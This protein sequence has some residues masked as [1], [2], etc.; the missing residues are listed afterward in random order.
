M[1]AETKDLSGSRIGIFGKGG[2][3]KSTVT[4]LL[5]RALRKRGY[6]VCVVDADSTNVGL[7]QA[8]GLDQS[9]E[10]LIDYFGGMVFSGGAV[11]CPVDDP[12]PLSG[13]KISVDEL[14]S[15]FVGRTEEGIWVVATGKMGERGP[16]AGCD[17]PMAKIS[18]DLRVQ[19][20]GEACLTLLDFKAGFEDSARGV[21][22]TLDQV[23]VVVD[24]TS[25]ALQMAIDMTEL[26]ERIKGGDSPATAH[27]ESPE[28]VEMATRLY[29]Q[30]RVQNVLVVLNRVAPE[31]SR[32]L[33]GSLET[34]GIHAAAAIRVDPWVAASWLIGKRL[35]ARVAEI[36]IEDLVGALE[37]EGSM[38]GESVFNV[39]VHPQVTY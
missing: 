12:M 29:Q 25:A 34:R 39:P 3:G 21:V 32:Y 38:P 9:P 22:V 36:D 1:K 4:V 11:T 26:I 37:A 10:S 15:R 2:S 19:V 31:S 13:A 33:R 7:H 5:A 20:N 17:G 30:A 27:L 18:R 23:V 28:L 6:E 16:G 24:P 8:I 35:E 14:P